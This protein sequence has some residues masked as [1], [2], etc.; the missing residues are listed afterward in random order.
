MSRHLHFWDNSNHIWS[1]TSKKCIEEE[2]SKSNVSAVVSIFPGLAVLEE[3]KSFSSFAVTS[4][5]LLSVIQ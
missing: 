1:D 4:A 2:N 3:K 5:F